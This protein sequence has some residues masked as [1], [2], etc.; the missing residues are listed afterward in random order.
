M[1]FFIQMLALQL[2][3]SV[4]YNNY[5]KTYILLLSLNLKDFENTKR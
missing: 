2:T 5:V 4:L 3:C 1:L